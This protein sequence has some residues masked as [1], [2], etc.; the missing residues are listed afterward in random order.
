MLN[1]I[2]RTALNPDHSWVRV[3]TDDLQNYIITCSNINKCKIIFDTKTLYSINC[4][5]KK[6]SIKYFLV[7][8]LMLMMMSQRQF[9]FS[10]IK[11]I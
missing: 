3:F 5:L 9:Y 6:Y 10:G 4:L 1:F 8:C 11:V 2:H 7:I